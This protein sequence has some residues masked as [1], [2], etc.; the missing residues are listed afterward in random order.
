MTM[1]RND[2]LRA[3]SPKVLHLAQFLA[4]FHFLLLSPAPAAAQEGVLMVLATKPPA[5]AAPAPA[6]PP[7]EEPVADPFSPGW[8]SLGLSCLLGT[9]P[10]D[11]GLEPTWL[12]G[13]DLGFR[14]DPQVA[15]GLRR[16]HVT[17][18]ERALV[19]GLSP[20]LEVS[21]R[22]WERLD[23]YGQ[24]G[25]QLD[26]LVP[27]AGGDPTGSTVP[28]AGGGARL[29]AADVFSVAVEGFVHAPVVG[30]LA[31]GTALLPVGAFHLSA[32][33]A[34]AFHWE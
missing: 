4:I 31:A 11:Q 30:G 8:V 28:F 21:A 2:G 25:V 5:P 34:L 6:P 32:G 13:I 23:L 27:Y 14:V 18:T 24:V 33:L 17:G 12:P 7:A 10:T 22:P 15:L 1:K 29:Y 19:I 3:R 20:Y 9:R 26:L 16:V